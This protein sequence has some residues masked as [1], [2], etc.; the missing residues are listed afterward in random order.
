MSVV[1]PLCPLTPS[2]SYI[3]SL[4]LIITSDVW[5]KV[6]VEH[7]LTNILKVKLADKTFLENAKTKLFFGSICYLLNLSS[8][9]TNTMGFTFKNDT[10]FDKA[11]ILLEDSNLFTE[12]QIP[13]HKMNYVGADMK[14]SLKSVQGSSKCKVYNMHLKQNVFME[15][16]QR[17]QC[18]NYPNRQY[19]SYDHCD[20]SYVLRKLTDMFGPEFLPI[21][22]TDNITKVTSSMVINQSTFDMV[23]YYNL[24][25]GVSLSPC[26]MPCTTTHTFTKL[27]AILD[28]TEP[29][30]YIVIRENM[31]VTTTS[32]VPFS[33][34]T[35]LSNLGGSLGLWLGLSMMQL[36]KL[37]IAGVKVSLKWFIRDGELEMY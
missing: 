37:L 18:T 16:D 35:F 9:L 2:V 14:V 5:K 28:Y 6:Q 21:W 13:D 31:K 12:R 25:D 23:K 17:S 32:L 29:T 4:I 8:T 19:T 20:H 22:A 24:G 10:K 1:P 3:L 15:E 34:T 11:A 36:G 26:Q 7:N 33:P 27:T 30:I